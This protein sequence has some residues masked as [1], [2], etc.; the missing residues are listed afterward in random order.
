M[1]DGTEPANVHT[2]EE[3]KVGQLDGLTTRLDNL[4]S[5]VHQ[6]SLQSDSQ[7]YLQQELRDSARMMEGAVMDIAEM[8][9]QIQILGNEVARLRE[10]GKDVK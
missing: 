3:E 6:L 9:R 1:P 7:P 5:Q 8:K 2:V 10:G 4:E